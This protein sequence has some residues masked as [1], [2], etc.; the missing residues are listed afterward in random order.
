MTRKEV[1]VFTSDD[2]FLLALG[3]AMDDR[4]RSRPTDGSGSWTEL[5]RDRRGV[6]L[7]DAS[8]LANAPEIVRTIE[9][10]FPGFAIVVFAPAAAH[11]Q[12]SP[13]LSRGAIARLIE[14]ETLSNDIIAAALETEPRPAASTGG[15]SA[16]A[17]S[18]G[19]APTG[20]ARWLLVAGI[21]AA[22]LA[23]GGA[24]WLWR[25]ESPPAASA[26]KPAAQPSGTPAP[27]APAPAAA[28]LPE[29]RTVPELLSA[30]RV[31]FAERRYLEP[32]GNNALELYARVLSAE[33]GNAEALDGLRRVLTI[34]AGQVATEIKAGRIE[35]ASR[36]YESLRAAAPDEPAVVALGADL[37]AARP[38]WLAARARD[39]IADQQFAAA[40][41]LIDELGAAGADRALVQ[42]LR[43]SLDASRRDADLARAVAEARASLG[44]GSLLDTSARG[45]RAR[46]TALQQIDRRNPQVVAFQREYQA[47]LTRSA[48]E[49]IRSG[50]FAGADRL[51]AVATDLGSSR[52]VSDARKEL[53]AA[54]D[55]AAARERERERTEA[56]RQRA[57]SAAAPAATR[58]PPPRMPKAKKRTPPEYPSDARRK[59]IEGYAIVEFGLTPD[60]HT[61]DLRV[62][63]SSPQG[64][65]DDAALDAV[66][67]WRFES[68]SEED[69]ARL[70]R[71]SV[72][73]GF[74]LGDR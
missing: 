37:S 45:P 47:A 74:R 56:A 5:L 72:R 19:D 54:R 7:I 63:E 67:S 49:A 42:D 27:A 66:R 51:L 31:A 34:A 38:K 17:E 62:T 57:A 10:G 20:R 26:T 39:A 11:A 35:D 55:S 50:D 1:V 16:R 4:Y 3:P 60:G 2:E 48:R 23:I 24:L 25:G 61:R 64:V 18:G 65:F 41:R 44:S 73:L 43:R 52:D 8:T 12:W 29:Q 59:G 58:A 13:A 71:A 53:Q 33:A 6:A 21:A 22:V 15:E 30:A 70:P 28:P 46:L 68:V 40:E 9:A 36:L 32:E 69:A 14:R